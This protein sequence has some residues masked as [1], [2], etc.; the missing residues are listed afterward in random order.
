MGVGVPCRGLQT[1]ARLLL[2]AGIV[3]FLVGHS[4]S[5]RENLSRRDS[6]AYWANA[7]L[8][9]NHQNAY[10]GY[11][12]AELERSQGYNEDQPLIVRT[13]PWSL[14]TLLP[15]A[16]FNAFWAWLSWIAV[17]VGALILT[18]R[19]CRRLYRDDRV[20]QS[21][22]ALIGYTFSPVAACLV[23]GQMGLVLLLGLVLFLWLEPKRPF[24]A[25]T[26]LILPFAKPHL[27]AV[28]WFALFLWIL[29]RKRFAVAAGFL[30]ALAIAIFTA[31]AF[32][33]GIFEHYRQMLS[34]SRIQGQFIPALSGVLRLLFFRRF[35][36]MQ[37][38]PLGL[39]LMWCGWFYW[40]QRRTWNWRQDALPLI[41]VSVL[42]T[43][44][45][46]LTDEVVL[47]PAILQAALWVYNARQNTRI[48]TWIIAAV[49][50]LLNALLLLILSF[51]I[52]FSTGIYFWSSSVWFAWFF[53]ARRY[54]K[55]LSAPPVSAGLVPV[56]PPTLRNKAKK[57]MH[58]GSATI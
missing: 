50:A 55:L 2:A 33:P 13:P 39:G 53:W 9:V 30:T 44:Y 56:L 21:L 18:M 15:L 54:S 6:I 34:E 24:L 42:V 29:S 8:L 58:N 49:F 11:A 7:R 35:F 19:V 57:K 16:L 51:K 4:E 12:V 14:F 45:A 20:P 40:R 48:G 43:P 10:D 28:F 41:V 37:F 36:A 25:G 31:I 22:F 1:L 3:Y 17:S 46:W 52:P 23:A 26:A 38:L 32:D 47:L 5:V 27:L